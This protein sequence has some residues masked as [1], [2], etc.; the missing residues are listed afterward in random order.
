M[1]PPARRDSDKVTHLECEALR[2]TLRAHG[3]KVVV[4]LVLIA[5]SAVA[6]L[7]RG[8]ANA[9]ARDTE[10]GL[11]IAAN[12]QE[13]VHVNAD[14]EEIK[15]DLKAVKME[16]TAQR[17][18]ITEGNTEVLAAVRSLQTPTATPRGN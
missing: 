2:G 13:I 15:T 5:L 1:T 10:H 17:I 11:S 16:I 6:W 3:W 8:K 9:Q 14:V 18:I 7:D 12:E 4:F